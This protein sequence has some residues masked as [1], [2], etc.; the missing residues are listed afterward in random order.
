M[1]VTLQ[2]L[3][4][5]RRAQRKIKLARRGHCNFEVRRDIRDISHRLTFCFSYVLQCISSPGV[6]VHH[7]RSVYNP[8]ATIHFTETKRNS[9]ARGQAIDNDARTRGRKIMRRRMRRVAS[10]GFA[11]KNS[12][13]K[14]NQVETE[15]KPSEKLS[16]GSRSSFS[17]ARRFETEEPDSFSLCWSERR[18]VTWERVPSSLPLWRRTE[19]EKRRQPWT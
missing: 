9:R 3:L 17:P 13:R 2:R 8:P 10:N 14:R 7:W 12:G 16:S 1:G 6:H 19:R 5:E 15:A 4:E 11:V 18:R